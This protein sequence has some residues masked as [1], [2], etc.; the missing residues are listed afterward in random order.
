M[1]SA[2]YQI[3]NK[4]GTVHINELPLPTVDEFVKFYGGVVRD[5]IH[6]RSKG[7]IYWC[8]Q[9]GACGD[10]LINK[11]IAATKWHEIKRVYNLC[12]HN[13]APKRGGDKYDYA[14]KFDQIYKVITN[15]VNNI[16]KCTCL[17]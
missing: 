12:N 5:A 11:A 15:N 1:F 2:L 8:W 4:I 17:D 6:R 3:S 13:T 14:Y 16:T 7:T 10:A 9:N